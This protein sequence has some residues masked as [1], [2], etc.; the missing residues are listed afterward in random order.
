MY[1]IVENAGYEGERDVYST[2]GYRDAIYWLCQNY[3]DEERDTL[4]VDI[5]RITKSGERSYEL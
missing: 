3:T 4:H 1:I 2:R 5:C